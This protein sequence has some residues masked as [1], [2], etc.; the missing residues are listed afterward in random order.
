MNGG[1]QGPILRKDP[2]RGGLWSNQTGSIWGFVS[3]TSGYPSLEELGSAEP[4][5]FA[6]SGWA[7]GTGPGHLRSAPRCLASLASCLADHQLGAL[8]SPKH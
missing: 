4:P 5:L 3:K 8:S 2:P 6:V 7:V 1:C